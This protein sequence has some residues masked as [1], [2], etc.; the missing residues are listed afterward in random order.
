[1]SKRVVRRSM[2]R[3][4][5]SLWSRSLIWIDEP[6][7]VAVVV[8][9]VIDVDQLDARLVEAHVLGDLRCERGD[10]FLRTCGSRFA[11]SEALEKVAGATF[12]R[13]TLPRLS[14][15][16]SI[17]ETSF[18][19]RKCLRRNIRLPCRTRRARPRRSHDK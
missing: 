13:R 6:C 4:S 19:P 11:Q 14:T 2:K 3:P 17:S 10:H 8:V 5:S 12:V 9:L 1:M 7:T 16:S 15:M 18:R